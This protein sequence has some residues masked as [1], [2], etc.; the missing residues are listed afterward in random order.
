MPKR[1]LSGTVFHNFPKKRLK[2]YHSFLGSGAV[3][4]LFLVE[5]GTTLQSGTKRYLNGGHHVDMKMALPW[6]HFCFT[7]F[8]S[9]YQ[10]QL[11][12]LQPKKMVP[13]PLYLDCRFTT[14]SIT[15]GRPD[16]SQSTC[17]DVH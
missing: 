16:V 11:T 13:I 1:F 9:V 4:N 6:S 5:N 3:I 17:M 7:F 2:R 15:P 14:Q 10:P 8:L 12:H